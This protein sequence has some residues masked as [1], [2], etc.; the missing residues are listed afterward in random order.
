MRKSRNV[1]T[2]QTASMFWY[3]SSDAQLV[4][5]QMHPFQF[6]MFCGR[7]RK[8][9]FEESER[10]AQIFPLM[11][12]WH[13]K[14]NTEEEIQ[15]HWS[16]MFP[17][18]VLRNHISVLM[19]FNKDCKYPCWDGLQPTVFISSF[20]TKSMPSRSLLIPFPGMQRRWIHIFTLF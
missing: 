5:K 14:E 2:I 13:S 20:V 3:N 12:V 18:T 9:D 17:H 7:N 6:T 15:V 8:W 1:Y 19:V 4:I 11:V 16:P 10:D